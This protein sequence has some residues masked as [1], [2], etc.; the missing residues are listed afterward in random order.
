MIVDSLQHDPHTADNA[1]EKR[2]GD[3]HQS[4]TGRE[5]G[6]GATRSKG[7]V[8]NSIRPNQAKPRAVV[9]YC[10]S[11]CGGGGDN[12]GVKGGGERIID[13]YLI[14]V[15]IGGGVFENGSPG[16][17]SGS[18]CA[19]WAL[20]KRCSRCGRCGRGIIGISL[21]RLAGGQRVVN[22]LN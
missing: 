18:G 1:R 15:C 13:D 21:Q 2:S 14:A 6:W 16:L 9:Q 17:S 5:V 12:Y 7:L 19:D 4:R 20:I 8:C 3:R 22:T 10:P 11:E